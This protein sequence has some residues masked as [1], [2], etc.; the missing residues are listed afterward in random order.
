MKMGIVH[1]RIQPD[2]PQQNGRH[3]RRH[4]I[5]KED[6]TKPPSAGDPIAAEEVRRFRAGRGSI[7]RELN[8]ETPGSLY[9]PSSV[10]LPRTFTDLM[11]L[12]EFYGLQSK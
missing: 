6:I 4:R 12:K 10:T 1:Q 8:N 7:A 9:Q 11:Y 3:Q 2:R 5:L